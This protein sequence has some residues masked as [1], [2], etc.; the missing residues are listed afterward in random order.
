MPC[1]SHTSAICSSWKCLPYRY[2]RYL[3]HSDLA[4]I[5]PIQGMSTTLGRH[6]FPK[7]HIVP[8][9]VCKY[10]RAANSHPHFICQLCIVGQAPHDAHY[11]VPIM[12]FVTVTTSAAF[13]TPSLFTS[14]LIDDNGF[15]RICLYCFVVGQ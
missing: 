11:S 4:Y 13:T 3:H 8:G 9:H 5:S 12:M 15:I 2:T 7:L 1:T 6:R 10:I 14:P